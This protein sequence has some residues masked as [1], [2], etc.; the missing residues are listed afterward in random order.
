MTGNTMASVSSLEHHK[1]HILLSYLALVI[2]VFALGFSPLFV[3]WANA[4]G[5]VTAFYRELIA[6]I[7]MFIPMLLLTK[8]ALP[9]SPKHVWYA[10]IAGVAF[11]ADIAL[12]NC[13]VFLTSAANATLF[14]N[15]SVLWVGLAALL[16]F[17][18]KL[19]QLFWIGLFIALIGIIIIVGADF[20]THPRLG[21]GD[22]MA[23]I[24]AIGYAAFFIA[25]QYSR[26]QLG[27]IS[28]FWFSAAAGA[29]FLLP[30]C[31]LSGKALIGYSSVTYWNFLGIA[32]ITQVGGY[33]AI[34]YALGYLPASIVSVTVLSQP[35][36]AAILAKLLLNQPIEPNQIIGGL[37]VLSGIIIVNRSRMKETANKVAAVAQLKAGGVIAYPTEAVFGLGCDPNNLTAVQQVLTLKRRDPTKGLILIASHWQQLEPFVKPLSEAQM[38]TLFATWPGPVTWVVPAAEHVSPLLRGKHQTIAVR[39]TAHPIARALCE[40]L[41]SAL[42]STSANR[43]G[44]PPCKTAA[45]A[46]TEFEEEQ[47]YIVQGNTG[48]AAKPT[49]IRD[50]LTQQTLRN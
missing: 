2:G 30:I 15:T 13:S 10:I 26:Q 11:A 12:W 3:L 44:L 9:L 20:L 25:T 21:A 43:E 34:N 19:G 28:S 5:V 41:G 23:M 4:P 38:Q 6:A 24:A 31:L 8:T 1:K 37:F 45:E 7:V 16:I 22:F 18:E 32:L 17:K 14:N 49:E 33:L 42:V 46:Q 35:I 29:L 36:V 27:V 48:G 40:G 47:V 50:L 39:I